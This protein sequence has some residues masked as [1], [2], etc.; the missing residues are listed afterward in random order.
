MSLRALF[1]SLP[2]ALSFSLAG[3]KGDSAD[4]DADKFVSLAEEA[5]KCPDMACAEK[6]KAK[7]DKLEDEMDAKYKDKK[8][9]EAKM[10]SISEKVEAAEDKA[11]ACAKKLAGA[12]GD[13]P[14]GGE[15]APAGGE[16]P[17]AGG[18]APAGGGN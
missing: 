9:D 13:A 2:L 16:A 11:K 5:C 8:M 6:V 4:A 7:W 3:C 17:P 1:L 12:G 10:K 14:A 18:E 15:A